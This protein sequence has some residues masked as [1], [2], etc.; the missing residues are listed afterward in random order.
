MEVVAISNVGVH[1]TFFFLVF[2]STL[3]FVSTT[4]Q[5]GLTSIGLLISLRK[6][7]FLACFPEFGP[8]CIFCTHSLR[9]MAG[10][11]DCSHNFWLAEELTLAFVQRHPEN[12]QDNRSQAL[13]ISC[14][15]PGKLWKLIPNLWGT[16]R[17][18]EILVPF[19]IFKRSGLVNHLNCLWDLCFCTVINLLT[20]QFLRSCKKIPVRN[21]I[22]TFTR[23]PTK[24]EF[25]AEQL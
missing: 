3:T 25:N 2:P 16:Q 6:G 18:S 13:S 15:K 24:R 14:K 23:L 7:D 9:I 17:S 4:S 8:D 12:H 19:R 1:S 20:R 11:L 5:T 21:A 22:A 10:S